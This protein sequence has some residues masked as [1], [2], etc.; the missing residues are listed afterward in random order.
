MTKDTMKIIKKAYERNM[1]PI[2]T[3]QSNEWFFSKWCE[4]PH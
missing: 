4:Y 2:I 3:S 1:K